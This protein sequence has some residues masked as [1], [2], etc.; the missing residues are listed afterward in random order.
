MVK[1]DAPSVLAGLF[2]SPTPDSKASL[3]G[4]SPAEAQGHHHTL[5]TSLKTLKL[6]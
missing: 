4:L 2:F 6:V 1:G 3:E 5:S